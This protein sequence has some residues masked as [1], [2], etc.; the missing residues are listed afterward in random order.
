MALSLNLRMVPGL[1]GLAR[2]PAAADIPAWI[3]G[4]GFS[5]TIRADDE[6]TI[7][8]HQARIP[9]DV[10]SDR[11]WVCFRSIGPFAFDATGIV[12][13]LVAPLSAAD[14]GVFVVCTFDGE[15]VLVPERERARSRLLLQEAGHR[16]LNGEA[17]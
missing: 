1:F 6:L 4:P 3:N 16:F 9:Q 15:H 13:A 11:A 8:C 2:L 17:D 5:A 14:I 10:Q 7:V 12:T